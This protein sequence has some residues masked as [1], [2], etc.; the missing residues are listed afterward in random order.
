M[1]FGLKIKLYK[2]QIFMLL[3]VLHI[4]K[5]LNRHQKQSFCEFV[6][7][8]FF[9]FFFLLNY[10]KNHLFLEGHFVSSLLRMPVKMWCRIQILHLLQFSKEKKCKCQ[11]MMLTFAIT[12][13]KCQYF[14]FSKM[15]TYVIVCRNIKHNSPFYLHQLPFANWLMIWYVS[16]FLQYSLWL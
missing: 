5:W 11:D 9:I 1:V 13:P 2:K 10:D 8:Y 12:L 15:V 3:C 14:T 16:S 4:W 6:E 7:A